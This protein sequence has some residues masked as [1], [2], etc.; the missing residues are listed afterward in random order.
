MFGFFDSDLKRVRKL[1]LEYEDIRQ[2]YLYKMNPY[3]KRMFISAYLSSEVQFEPVIQY[4]SENEL[5]RW[6]KMGSSLKALAQKT[7]KDSIRMAGIGGEGY[8]AG[9]DGLALLALEC[10]A[11]G[12]RIPESLIL[13]GDI[14]SF[15]A[16]AKRSMGSSGP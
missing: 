13:K 5:E 16:D 10:S 14:Q 1:R 12:S 8:I 11:K 4:I 15:I 7:W 3:Q 2:R 6:Q 9:V